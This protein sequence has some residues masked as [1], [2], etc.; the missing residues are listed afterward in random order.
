MAH[1]EE[2]LKRHTYMLNQMSQQGTATSHP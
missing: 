1:I 2:Q